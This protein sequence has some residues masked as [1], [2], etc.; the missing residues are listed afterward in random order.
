[1]TEARNAEPELLEIEDNGVLT[2]VLNRPDN[3]NALNS[4]LMRLLNEAVARAAHNPEVACVILTGAGRAFCAGGDMKASKAAREQ[5]AAK[6]AE[7]AAKSSAKTSFQ[8]RAEWLRRSTEAARLLH[9][10]A[11]PTIAMINGACAGAGLS[12]AGACDIRIAG[13]S[14]MLTSVFARAGLSG[15]YGGSWFWTRILG[16]A[17][18]RELYMLCERI[19][20][21]Q[22]L[23][24][25][26]VT[27]VHEDDEL[28]VQVMAMARR[29]A[30]GPRAAYGYMKRNLN[31]AETGTLDSLLDLE[32]TH[33]LLSR[34]ALSK[35]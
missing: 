2:L 28:A 3:L 18:A 9:E 31:T 22:A 35:R 21:R 29:F 23:A 12:L 26:M 30:D 14:A 32:A 6:P 25:G 10:M 16:T 11:K 19:D 13:E 7:D 15:D 8:A 5:A 17:K 4:S 27:A 33:M 1:M 24:A 20:A 34:E